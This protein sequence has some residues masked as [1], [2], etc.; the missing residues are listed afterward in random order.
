MLY[1]LFFFIFSSYLTYSTELFKIKIADR[2]YFYLAQIEKHILDGSLDPNELV[3]FKHYL[4]PISLLSAIYLDYKLNTNNDHE[5]K[6]QVLKIMDL[7]LSKGANPDTMYAPGKI[8]LFDV[9]NDND[10]ETLELLVKYKVNLNKVVDSKHSLQLASNELFIKLVAL[11]ADINAVVKNIKSLSLKN[12]LLHALTKN[13]EFII[14]FL[15]RHGVIVL[16]MKSFQ[17]R[18]EG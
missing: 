13:N 15:F 7:I 10:L 4:E 14:E 16:K 12:I 8:I 3:Y 6:I 18:L 1:N 5:R 2:E 11:G 9:I 17:K